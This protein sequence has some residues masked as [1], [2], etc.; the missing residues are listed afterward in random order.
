MTDEFTGVD[1]ASRIDLDM[2]EAAAER[3]AP[4]IVTT[5]LLESP[6]LN[7]WLGFRLL[8]KPENLQ[9]TGSFKLR[10]ASN[11][12]WS[13]DDDVDKIFAYSSG[14]HA[15]GVAR[16][17][18]SRGLQARILMPEDSPRVKIAG[19]IAFGGIV[20]TYDRYSESREE[21][22]ERMAT[23]TGT[24]LIR[25]YEDTRVIAGQ[26]TVGL[27]IAAQCTALGVTPDYL[28]CCCGGGGLIAGI[29]IA[30]RAKMP[31]TRIWGGG[32]GRL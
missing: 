22:G 11:A 25:P 27:E 4:H 32:T 16:A 3:I 28:V 23:E 7:D 10:G 14:N 20:V 18:T 31:A 6:R 26:G 13:L 12:I 1:A 24:V 21:I 19:T 9:H 17:A 8:V 5:P 29:S 2:I 15:Q 30:L